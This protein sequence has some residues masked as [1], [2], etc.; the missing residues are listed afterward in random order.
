[1]EDRTLDQTN[2][3]AREGGH[4]FKLL[5]YRVTIFGYTTQYEKPKPNS[6]QIVKTIVRLEKR[7]T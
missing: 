6:Y 4:G 2:K 1:M 3:T 7:V 5:Q